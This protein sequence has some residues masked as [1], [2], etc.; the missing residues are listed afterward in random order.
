MGAEKAIGSVVVTLDGSLVLL[1][2]LN[3]T[4]EMDG[5]NRVPV[6][7]SGILLRGE[8][9]MGAR[10][11]IKWPDP[12]RIVSN[13]AEIIQLIQKSTDLTI[14]PERPVEQLDPIERIARLEKELAALR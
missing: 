9:R 4:G 2:D 11:N 13:V 12:V 7:D 1:T 8:G 5:L 6:Y 3:L 14:K 10:Y